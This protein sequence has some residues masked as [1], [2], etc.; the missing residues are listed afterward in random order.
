[1]TFALTT[2]RS[3]REYT[4]RMAQV[5]RIHAGKTP[6]RRH[7]LVEWA[8]RR[9]VSQADLVRATGADKAAVSRW[10]N[11]GVIPSEKHIDNVA[12][13]LQVEDVASLFRHPDDDW[14]SRLFKDRDE[15]ERERLRQMIELAFPAKRA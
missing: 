13:A 15:E 11:H 7:Y 12:L 3:N 2:H 14:L 8:E 5:T 6:V 4:L 10:F 9:G 1:M